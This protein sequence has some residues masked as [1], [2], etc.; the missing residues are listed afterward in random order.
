MACRFPGGANDPES[1]W[2]LLADGVDAIREIPQERWPAS[3]ID[4]NELPALRWAGLIDSVDGF[5]AEFFGITPREA[6]QLDP[7]QRLLLEVSWEALE[8]ALQPADRLVQHPVGVFVGIASSDYQ[9]H[10]LALPP[11]EQNGYS[12]TGNMPSVA[13]G[14]IAYTLGLQGP[15]AAVDT[16]CSS[17]LVALHL[18]CQSLRSGE[19]ALALAGGVNLLLSPTWMRMVGLTQSLSPDGRCR[20][21]DARAN[22]FV[23]GEGCGVVVLKRLSDAQRDGDHVWALLR[24]S[25]INHDG[26][27]GGLTVPNVLSQEATLRK[28][29]DSAE[30]AAGD[31][32]Y[33]EAHGTGTPIGDPIELE[34]LKSVLG[35]DRGDER[36]CVVG[37]VKTNIGHLEAAAGIAGLI[38]VVLA[39]G[40]ETIPAH[41]HFRGLNPRVSLEQTALVIGAEARP[42]P[43]G[44]VPRRAVVSS[45]GISGTNAGVVVEEAPPRPP[46]GAAPRPPA[47]VGIPGEFLLPLSARSPEALRALALAHAR[48]L[49]EPASQTS[50]E[51]HVHLASTRRVHHPIRQG[52]VG[53]TRAELVESLMAFAGQPELPV[54]ATIKAPRIAM[55]F[56]GQGSQWLGM[57][58]ELRAREPVFRDALAEFDAAIRKVAGW[59]VLDE[60]FAEAERARLDQV[61]VIQPCIVAIQIALA[62][63][64][65]SWGVEPA[66]VVGQSMGEVSA[67]YVAGALGLEDAARVITARSRLVKQLRGG[68][69]ASVELPASEL[70]GALGEGLGVAAINGPTS[71]LVAG[72]SDAIERLVT[73]MAGRGVF[74]RKVK[75]DYASHSPEVE[76]LRVQLLEALSSV[77]GQ[78]PALA[79]RSTVHRGWVGAG[80]LGPEYWYQNLREPVQL[81]PVLEELLIN[82]GIDV[83]LEVSPHPILGPVLQAASAHAGRD[84]AV[85]ASLR[86]EQ[87][88][89]KT[90]LLT[91]AALYARGQAVAFE[92][93]GA[94][95]AVP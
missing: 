84:A 39:L 90:L 94:K 32:G 64:W 50:L 15:C 27:S 75:V 49:G 56:P 37:S 78:P 95:G 16:A 53:G 28:A 22:G 60:L 68:A 87:A 92:R 62:A 61:D 29:L 7:Q 86:R 80:D 44:E 33:V 57:G 20:T 70:E 48:R 69:M 72:R 10:V 76:P 17:S 43:A 35:R 46:G 3:E 91:L 14:R 9:H 2:R 83:L 18:A 55:I 31:I 45:F 67:A 47:D 51:Q 23:R 5:D 79:F 63:L 36:R 8:N 66:V 71:T 73:E 52:F 12:A 85:F 38:K 11:E 88:E 58:R 77:R 74:C 34:A 54:A 89:Q 24:G 81:F 21:F 1:Y 59:S 6:A 13:A 40:Q 25:S 42:W 41:L 4:V 65:R 93:V 30:V 19:S 26:R 82:D